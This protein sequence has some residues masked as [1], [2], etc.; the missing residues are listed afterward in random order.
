[1]SISARSPVMPVTPGTQDTYSPRTS[2]V[3]RSGSTVMNSVR[4]VWPSRASSS[5]QA[6]TS[7]RVVGHTSGQWVKPKKTAVG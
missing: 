4:S 6:V 7:P 5:C 3:S 1:M 2:R